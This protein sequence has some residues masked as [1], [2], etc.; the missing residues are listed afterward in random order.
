M[1]DALLDTLTKNLRPVRPLR[2][3]RLWLGAGAGL[4]VAVIYILVFYHPRN[5]VRMLMHGHWSGNPMA[6][7]KPLMFLV[8]GLSALWATADLSRPEGRLK[9]SRLLAL[10]LMAAAVIAGVIYEGVVFGL[11][12]YAAWLSAGVDVCYMTILCGGMAGWL[13]MWRFWL[14]RT[15]S[16]QPRLLGAMSGLAAASLMAAAYAL[17]CD[18]DAPIYLLAVYGG[19]V[20]IFTGIASLLG[21]RFLRW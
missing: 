7:V 16:S 12:D 1:S 19:A 6:V 14:R 13:V 2:N 18:G 21:G 20:A 5:D 17:H 9:F 11:H 15:A 8:L 3:S 10:I 4:V